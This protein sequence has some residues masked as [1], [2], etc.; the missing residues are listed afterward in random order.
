MKYKAYVS[1][2]TTFPVT[3]EAN[4]IEDAEERLLEGENL[5]DQ[6]ILDGIDWG[7]VNIETIESTGE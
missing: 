4:C 7:S 5:N 6:D 2:V 3:V 1:V